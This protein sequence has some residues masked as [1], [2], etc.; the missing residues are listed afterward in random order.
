MERI[1]NREKLREGKAK[2]QNGKVKLREGKVKNQDGKAKI[3]DGKVKIREGK[4]KIR[5]G[6]DRLKHKK[7]L[8]GFIKNLR[9]RDV[10]ISEFRKTAVNLFSDVGF[11]KAEVLLAVDDLQIKA[12]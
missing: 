12:D 9:E 6:K 5:E 2:I 8:S 7:P 10:S 3:R 11:L 4:V 1:G